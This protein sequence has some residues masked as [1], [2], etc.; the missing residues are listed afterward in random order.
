MS[1]L[2]SKSKKRLSQNL[3]R[4]RLKIMGRNLKKLRKCPCLISFNKRI[5]R[6]RKIKKSS[7]K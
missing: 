5:I 6:Q 1:S 2:A 3:G 4:R 7:R